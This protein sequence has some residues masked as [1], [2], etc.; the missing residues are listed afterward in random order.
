MMI[1]ATIAIAAT[2]PTTIPAIAPPLLS[3]LPGAGVAVVVP[4]VAPTTVLVVP[5]VAPTTVPV[6]V[7]L[8][9]SEV[10]VPL[11][12]VLPIL[13]ENTDLGVESGT[14]VP[15]DSLGSAL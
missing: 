10:L 5:E 6:L 15:I 4:E 8:T 14:V 3:V 1:P 13:V 11:V 2:A 9:D 7:T 12:V